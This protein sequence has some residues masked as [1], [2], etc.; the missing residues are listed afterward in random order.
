MDIVS[1]Q[2]KF[3]NL[4]NMN[5]MKITKKTS[6]KSILTLNKIFVWTFKISFKKVKINSLSLLI[7]KSRT[8]FPTIPSI[9]AM[10]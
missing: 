4:S 2:L 7:T 3:N 6:T 8:T 9:P 5:S 10:V 1:D